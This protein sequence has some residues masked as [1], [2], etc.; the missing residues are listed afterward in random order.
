MFIINNYMTNA[1]LNIFFYIGTIIL[2][3]YENWM[4]FILAGVVFV[5]NIIVVLLY[6][7]AERE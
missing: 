3:G 6:I 1:L 7:R 2:S 5:I 4:I